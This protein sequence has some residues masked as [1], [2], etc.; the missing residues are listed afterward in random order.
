[1]LSEDFSKTLVHRRRNE[2]LFKAPML[3]IREG[4][5]MENL[6]LKG[7]ISYRDCIFKDSITSIKAFDHSC[8]RQLKQFSKYH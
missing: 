8:L 6:K 3:L 5:D 7:A 4:L 2:L 1:M